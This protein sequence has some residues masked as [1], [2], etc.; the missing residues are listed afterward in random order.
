M[1]IPSVHKYIYFLI[2]SSYPIAS[3]LVQITMISNLDYNKYILPGFLTSFLL[4][5]N[6][7]TTQQPEWSFGKHKS[8][9]ATPLINICQWFPSTHLSLELTNPCLIQPCLALPGSCPPRP[10]Q[11]SHQASF[12]SWIHQVCF[13]LWALPWAITSDW[14]AL[15]LVFARQLLGVIQRLLKCSSSER[16]PLTT[17]STDTQT[18]PHKSIFNPL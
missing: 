3:I 16:P 4:P 6:S 8:N 13:Y 11:S 2:H 1:N 15:L 12:V 17:Q 18:L 10:P 9:H 14:N 5:E 7:L